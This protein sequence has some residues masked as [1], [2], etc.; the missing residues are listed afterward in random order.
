MYWFEESENIWWSTSAICPY[1]CAEKKTVHRIASHIVHK[2]EWIDLLSTTVQYVRICISNEVADGIA[3]CTIIC[4]DS[5]L[6]HIWLCSSMFNIVNNPSSLFSTPLPYTMKSYDIFLKFHVCKHIFST[7]YKWF[8]VEFI[9]NIF[10]FKLLEFNLTFIFALILLYWFNV[11]PSMQRHFTFD[12]LLHIGHW[13]LWL[14]TVMMY[15]R[16]HQQLLNVIRH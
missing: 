10:I 13:S 2:W 9:F 12:M 8:R 1:L 16:F 11:K 15:G 4:H 6:F 5:I 3:Y 14:V 7:Y